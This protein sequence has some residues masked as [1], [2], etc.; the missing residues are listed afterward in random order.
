MKKFLSEFEL[1]G[2]NAQ[3]KEHL[4]LISKYEGDIQNYDKTISDL[5][6][7]LKK[8][9]KDLSYRKALQEENNL[10][11]LELTKQK[12]ELVTKL[13]KEKITQ[14]NKNIPL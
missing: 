10:K 9:E 6:N 7:D 2:L 12:N 13:P 1:N 8:K 11:I 3:L 5:T 4:Q 14:S